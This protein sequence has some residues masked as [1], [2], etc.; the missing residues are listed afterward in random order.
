MQA[1]QTHAIIT[2]LRAKVDGSLG[3]S[4]ST[5]ELS[6]SEK[7]A[8]MELQNHNCSMLI[9]PEGTAVMVNVE[10]CMEGKTPSERL[11]GVFYILWKQDGSKGTFQ[12]YYA[13]K[14]EQLKDHFKSKIEDTY[15][16]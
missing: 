7:V 4:V 3:L 8:F 15:G 16:S 1:I 14:M 9:Q 6:A 11:R 5:P 10:K 12:T 2:G 13:T